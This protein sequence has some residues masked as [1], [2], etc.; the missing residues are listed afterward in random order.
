MPF[1]AIPTGG[2]TRP[3]PTHTEI[4]CGTPRDF[5]DW[6]NCKKK[7]RISCG[8]LVTN[9]ECIMAQY[10]SRRGF[11]TEVFGSATWIVSSCDARI[12]NSTSV[13]NPAWVRAIIR[14]YDD[15]PMTHFTGQQFLDAKHGHLRRIVNQKW[16]GS[17]NY[18]APLAERE[19]EHA[20]S[21]Q[22]PPI[23]KAETT[24]G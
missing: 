10:F 3:E 11:V 21:P 14:C 9:T 1:D 22:T 16:Q 18:I 12:E 13:P 2:D 8:S 17:G 7:M 6:L 15:M 24:N 4:L 19:A 23:V 20:I 5:F